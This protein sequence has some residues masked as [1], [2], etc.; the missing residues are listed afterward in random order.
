MPLI[1]RSS[2]YDAHS[3]QS[4]ALL[5]ARRPYLVRNIFT[6]LGIVAFTVGVYTYTIKSVGSDDFDDVVPMK[7]AQPATAPNAGAVQTVGRT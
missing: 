6:G 1:P 2:Y 5:R 3:R 4:E 7:P